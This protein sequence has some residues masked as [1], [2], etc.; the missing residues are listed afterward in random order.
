MATPSH[1]EFA[2][3]LEILCAYVSCEVY[4]LIEGYD[5]YNIVIA[6]LEESF[7]KTPN[8]TFSCHFLATRKQKSRGIAGRVSASAHHQIS[9]IES[10]QKY[11]AFEAKGK[12]YEFM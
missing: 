7:A 1:E 4:E 8:A 6:K 12:P 3:K 9:L 10:E 11:T 2:S 5:S